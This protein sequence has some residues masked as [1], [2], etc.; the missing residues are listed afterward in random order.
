[1]WRL[2]AGHHAASAGHLF[3]MPNYHSPRPCFLCDRSVFPNDDL[4]DFCPCSYELERVVT[5]GGE[6]DVPRFGMQH[7]PLVPTDCQD[8]QAVLVVTVKLPVFGASYLPTYCSS[9]S[10]WIV[11]SFLVLSYGAS[12]WS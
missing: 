1:M 8:E 9:T 11:T 12:R 10:G 2:N 4:G 7:K 3:P 5:I 6:E